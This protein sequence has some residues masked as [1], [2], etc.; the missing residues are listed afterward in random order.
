MQASLS[1][2]LNQKIMANLLQNAGVNPAHK[3]ARLSLLSVFLTA[4]ATTIHH[5]Y[6]LGPPALIL[7]FVI[8]VFPII[9]LL[10][11]RNTKKG[12]PL[13][14]YGLMNLWIISGFGVADGFWDSV[15]KIYFSNFLFRDS[16]LFIRTPVRSYFFELTGVLAFFAS[17]FAAYYG[18]KFFNAVFSQRQEWKAWN[19]R[20]K[21]IIGSLVIAGVLLAGY[22]GYKHTVIIPENKIVK[23]GVIVP[24]TG[25]GKILGTSFLKA[26]ELAS[27]DVKNKNTKYQY[28]IVIENSG[29][30]PAETEQ[31][32]E[33][34]IYKEQVQGIVGGISASGKIV[35]PYATSAKIPHLCVCSVKTIG[36][37]KYNFTNI[38]T[39]EDEAIQW[40]EEAQKRGIKSIAIIN[41]KYP[42]IEGHVRALKEES[43]KAGIK[44]LYEKEFEES[45]RD[46]TQMIAEAKNNLPDIYFISGFPPVLDT[47][48]VQLKRSGVNNVASIVALSV[49][50][51]PELFE[52]NWYTDSYVDSSFKARFEQKY[53]GTRFATHMMPYAYDSFIIMVQAF[54]SGKDPAEYIQ[55]ITEYPGTSGRLT[56]ETGKGNFR[57]RPAV[58]VIKNGKP[59]LLHEN[60]NKIAIK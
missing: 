38:P 31:A 8:I 51:K 50:N 12:L 20:V 33:R 17:M 44:I 42:S 57:S 15:V 25:P 11:F 10:W 58:W 54:E 7:G 26:V 14:L 43:V 49:S 52:G 45:A 22:S 28:Q 41:Q 13:L 59:E 2:T 27:E 29:I 30:T 53:P 21:W 40:V 34:L 3:F 46:F 56:K 47:L 6:K 24:A 4:T 36:D 48:G 32:I 9:F 5:V 55:N 37:G 19:H 1:L 16:R 35:K 60:E 18:Y 23:I 39:A